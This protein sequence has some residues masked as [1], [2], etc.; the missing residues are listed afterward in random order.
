MSGRRP[1]VPPADSSPP[2]T[3]DVR[4]PLQHLELSMA[5][6]GGYESLPALRVVRRNPLDGWLDAAHHSEDGCLVLDPDGVV[7]G[8]SDVCLEMLGIGAAGDILGRGLLDDLVE[9][10]DFS[11]AEVRPAPGELSKMPPL[12]ALHS[13]GLARGLIRVRTPGGVSTLDA[14]AAAVHADGALAG[15]VTFLSEV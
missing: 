15:S 3:P 4:T 12:L 8:I 10:V 2:R 5:S 14:V 13:G 1:S 7:A 9:F 6:D 11:A